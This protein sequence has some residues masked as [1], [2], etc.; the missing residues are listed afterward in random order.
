MVAYV[1]GG[2][3][4]FVTRDAHLFRTPP[5]DAQ[6]DGLQALALSDLALTL[7]LTLSLTHTLTY[8]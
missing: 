1:R 2:Q 6:I 4:P 8:P 5:T 7:S 3:Q